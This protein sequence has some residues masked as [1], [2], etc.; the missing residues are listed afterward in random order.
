MARPYS[1][2]EKKKY[3]TQ[4]KKALKQG[5]SLSAACH[6]V[7]ERNDGQPSAASLTKWA[8]AAGLGSGSGRIVIA[9][10]AEK[11]GNGQREDSTSLPA[12]S[13]EEGLDAALNGNPVDGADAL[14]GVIPAALETVHAEGRSDRETERN[15]DSANA[16]G[17]DLDGD[18]E[19]KAAYPNSETPVDQALPVNTEL[20]HIAT[21]TTGGAT[22]EKR[23]DL[24]ESNRSLRTTVAEMGREIRALRDLLKVYVSR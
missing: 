8:K 18:A 23:E 11:L 6:Q 13:V 16:A 17:S 4:V 14:D 2:P 24:I 1:D 10:T 19:G 20:V 5:V 3:L 12:T 21:A 7:A 15:G 9:E 22:P